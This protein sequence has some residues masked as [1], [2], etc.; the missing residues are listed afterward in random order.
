MTDHVPASPA[1]M[2]RIQVRLGDLG[3][4]KENLRFHEPADDGV[5][6][7]A[8]TLLAAGVVIPPIVRPGRKGEAAF[9]AL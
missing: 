1:A 2:S 8:D 6:Q 5:P 7:L 9:M 4:A 3:L